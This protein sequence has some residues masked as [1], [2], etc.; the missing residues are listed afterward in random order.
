[1]RSAAVAHCC[2]VH[3]PISRLLRTCLRME[4]NVTFQM[5]SSIGG[6]MPY[7]HGRRS[8]RLQSEK[9][10]MNIVLRKKCQ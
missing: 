8:Y 6:M 9:L 5:P 7:L 10:V 3:R 1:M 2:S 4:R